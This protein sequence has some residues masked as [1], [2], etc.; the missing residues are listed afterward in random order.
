MGVLSYSQEFGSEG[1]SEEA[2][3]NKK[4]S[5]FHVYEEGSDT[6]VEKISIDISCPLNIIM[7]LEHAKLRGNLALNLPD[8]LLFDFTFNSLHLLR[9]L[10]SDKLDSTSYYTELTKE[11]NHNYNVGTW[12]KLRSMGKIEN[13]RVLVL[14]AGS[15]GYYVNVIGEMKPKEL[16]FIDVNPVTANKLSA[17]LS[18]VLPSGVDWKV[19]VGDMFFQ[20]LL[21]SLRGYDCIICLKALGQALGKYFGVVADSQMVT[22]F[23]VDWVDSL[24]KILIPDGVIVIDEPALLSPEIPTGTI[25]TAKH[26]ASQED[27]DLYS[28]GGRFRND[29]RY[30]LDSIRELLELEVALEWTPEGQEVNGHLGEQVWRQFIFRKSSYKNV[31]KGDLSDDIQDK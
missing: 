27:F 8:E 9:K 7:G 19:Q 3:G 29:M 16:C 17:M 12:E 21:E 28:I 26:F 15:S 1:S 31:P 14:G 5:D 13:K 24:A 20:N 6:M 10:Q 23:I 18:K 2:C 22:K 25:L 11:A 4:M 30:S